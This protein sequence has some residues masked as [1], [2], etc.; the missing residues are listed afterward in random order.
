MHFRDTIVALLP[1]THA[2]EANFG[3]AGLAG[4]ERRLLSV[5]GPQSKGQ[6]NSL[7]PEDQDSLG[8]S[9]LTAP[10]GWHT[11]SSLGHSWKVLQLQ[12]ELLL[13]AS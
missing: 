5:P 2:G 9:R 1:G 13:L 8:G 4:G 6:G 10:V 11:F 7:S 3:H 12:K